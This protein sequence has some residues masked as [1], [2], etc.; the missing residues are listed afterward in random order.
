MTQ[1]TQISPNRNGK[2]TRARR[3]D[4]RALLT[5]CALALGACAS[6]PTGS[7]TSN[8]TPAVVSDG[9]PDPTLIVDCMLPGKIKKLGSAMTYVTPRR[10][11]KASS[12]ECEIRGGEYVSYDRADFQTALNVWRP[13]AEQGDPAAQTYVGAIYEKGLGVAPD[14][15]QAV[16]WYKQ[17]A[18]QGY[19]R[20][21]YSLGYLY[22]MG[23]GVE[24]DPK[25]AVRWYRQAAGIAA[26]ELS[27][28]VVLLSEK[29]KA[30]LEQAAAAERTE[31]AQVQQQVSAQ[32][33]E[34]AQL[35]QDV[36]AAQAELQAARRAAQQHHAAA[37]RAKREQTRVESELQA[38][39]GKLDAL[40][41][42]VQAKESE[43]ANAE[44]AL[45]QRHQGLLAERSKLDASVQ[46]TTSRR[47]ALDA[48][49]TQLHE[50]EAAVARARAQADDSTLQAKA[51]Q[52]EQQIAGKRSE[53]TSVEE[54]LA[55]QRALAQAKG[56]ELRE[57]LRDI[58]QR[59]IALRADMDRLEATRRATAE[60]QAALLA[61]QQR[62]AEQ[63]RQEQA[64]Y[65]ASLQREKQISAQLPSAAPAVVASAAPTMV[66]ALPS[67]TLAL[68]PRIEMIDPQ[69]PKVRS[70]PPALPVL[71]VSGGIRSRDIVGRVLADKPLLLVSVNDQRVTLQS[72]GVF[73][74]NVSVVQD[75]TRVDV[76]AVDADGNR[77][78]TNF[79]LAPQQQTRT[80]AA[81]DTTAV[82][83]VAALPPNLDFGN[84]HALLIG[85]NDYKGLPKLITPHQDV[86]AL[87]KVLNEKY[88]FKETLV[89]KDA[90]RYDI[91]TSLNKLR[92]SLTEKDNLLVYYAGHGEL[93][94]VNMTGQWLP[95]DAEPDNTANWISNSSLTELVNAIPAKR[96]MVVADSCYSGIL[97]RSALATLETGRSEDARFT[98]LEKM[99]KK[100]SRTVLTSGGVAPVLD[101]GGGDH[102]VFARALLQALESNTDVLEGQRLFRQVS[103]AVAVAA[104]RYKVDQVPEYAPIRHAGHESGDFFLVP[105]AL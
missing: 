7:E 78:E 10:P 43:L 64:K 81:I 47:M 67:D 1:D 39:A 82:N 11:V 6:A 29:E 38:R 97:A 90:T 57:L 14:F 37:N 21:Q 36:A 52:I 41:A 96:V 24:K 19:S 72:N 25:E 74:T 75:G 45:Q 22:E 76:V 68:A 63:L 104:D 42:Q 18:E 35:S 73:S 33:S 58:E 95:V 83:A 77:G 89:L 2:N 27:A 50:A 55:R 65:Q 93:D 49:L 15:Q 70:G 103:A 62:V 44:A 91:T 87:A 4:R 40:A 69:V 3:F 79:V 101:E 9:R 59:K 28:T 48:E 98:W 23:L 5:A 100:R 31:L 12:Q 92:A 51:A 71:L 94:R 56:E 8:E 85:N 66:S 17:A 102:S 80:A 46:E 53:L 20:A 32:Q 88:G 60:Q 54:T 34:L 99:L 84:F 105:R 26:E 13:L 30:Q 61:E 16:R 86:D